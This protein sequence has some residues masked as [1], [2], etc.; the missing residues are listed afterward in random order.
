MRKLQKYFAIG[1][2]FGGAFAIPGGPAFMNGS[3]F[4][5]AFALFLSFFNKKLVMH[6]YLTVA[7]LM[8]LLH[9]LVSILFGRNSLIELF[10]VYTTTAI[11]YIVAYNILHTKNKFEESL[12]IYLRIAEVICWI[13]VFQFLMY[14][15]GPVF[16]Y[17]YSWFLENW[18]IVPGGPFGLR[19]SGVL[20][21]PSQ[22]GLTCSLAQVI[23]VAKIFGISPVQITYRTSILFILVVFLSGSTLAMMNLSLAIVVMT[24]LSFKRSWVILTILVVGLLYVPWERFDVVTSRIAGVYQLFVLG[25]A[26]LDANASSFT[27]FK[28]YL[29][30]K[31]NLID[32]YGFG[33]G[34]GSHA[35]TYEY[36]RGFSDLA[37]NVLSIGTAGNLFNR[38]ISELG[39]IG[40]ILLFGFLVIG[41]KGFFRFSERPLVLI[42]TL[43][44]VP[45]LARNGTYAYYGVAFYVSIIILAIKHGA[46][47]EIKGSAK[48]I[49]H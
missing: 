8:L 10:S 47:L 18:V 12:R 24:L 3:L 38:L 16:L 31:Q 30:A 43:A 15:I 42:A 48:K 11:F 14:W 37:H 27:I 23:A 6:R 28:H 21:E 13:V 45:F 9:G 44:I 4:L 49:N 19:A 46:F 22:L 41:V 33:S 35:A 20:Y 7:L 29:I 17:D 32:S 36:Y 40:I 34:M 25:D 5:V 1:S 39:A 26:D 2:I